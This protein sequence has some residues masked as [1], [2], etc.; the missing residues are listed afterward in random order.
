LMR[1]MMR[2]GERGRG[3]CEQANEEE[4]FFHGDQN[5]TKVDRLSLVFCRRIRKAMQRK[6]YCRDRGLGTG[7]C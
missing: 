3:E 5:G 7:G 4:E 2:G 1:G 6:G